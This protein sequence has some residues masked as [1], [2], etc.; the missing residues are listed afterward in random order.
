MGGYMIA[1]AASAFG[2][3]PAAPGIPTNGTTTPFVAQAE[4]QAG[5]S[6]TSVFQSISAMPAYRNM[7]H[8]ELRVMDYLQ[9]RKTPT[10]GA[11]GFGTSTTVS[12][13]GAPASNSAFGSTNTT[14]FGGGGT[15]SAFGSTPSAFGTGGTNSFGSTSTPNAFGSTSQPSAFG[16]GTGFGSSSTGSAFGAPASTSAFGAAAPATSTAFSGTGTSTFGS[17]TPATSGF[18]AFGG[19]TS[20]TKPFGASTFGGGAFGSSTSNATNSAF[21]STAPASNAFGATAQPQTSA[22]GSTTQPSTSGFGTFGLTAAK[23]ATTFGSFGTAASTAPKPFGGFGTTTSSNPANPFATST[24]PSTNTFGLGASSQPAAP[25]AS[26]TASTNPFGASTFGVTNTTSP[27]GASTLNTTSLG[28]STNTPLGNSIF[29]QTQQLP[30]LHASVDQD[31]YGNSSLFANFKSSTAS[32][33]SLVSNTKKQPPLMSMLRTSSPSRSSVKKIRG[34]SSPSFGNALDVSGS[35]ASSP[36]SPGSGTNSPLKFG[37]GLGEDVTVSPLAFQPRSSVKK[38]VIDRTVTKEELIARALPS[39]DLASSPATNQLDFLISAKQKPIQLDSNLEKSAYL[40][41]FQHKGIP[42]GSLSN[43]PQESSLNT[44]QSLDSLTSSIPPSAATRLPATTSQPL[45]SEE[46]EDNA[47]LVQSEWDVDIASLKDG[48]YY[49]KPSLKYIATLRDVK[50]FPDLE[51][52]RKGHGSV[53]FM[54]PVDLSQLHQFKDLLGK[55]VQ[56]SDRSINVYPTGYVAK[57]PSVGEGINVPAVVRL[58]QC[59]PHDKATRDPVKDPDDTRVIKHIKRLKKM[60][61]TKFV[62]YAAETGTWTFQVQHFSRYG[63]YDSDDE[64]S[65]SDSELGKPNIDVDVRVSPSDGMEDDLPP[66]KSLAEGTDEEEEEDD[67]ESETE[68]SDPPSPQVGVAKFAPSRY[69]KLIS[70]DEDS[71]LETESD[72]DEKLPQSSM[73]RYRVTTS[74]S[75]CEPWPKKLGLEPKRVA[76]MQASLFAAESSPVSINVPAPPSSRSAVAHLSLLKPT[77]PPNI[78]VRSHPVKRYDM[79]N[80][81][82]HFAP[83]SSVD[84]GLMLGR[85]F[86][87]SWGSKGQLVYLGKLSGAT[88]NP[89]KG[90]VVIRKVKEESDLHLDTSLSVHLQHTIIE[91]VEGIPQAIPRSSL[92]FADLASQFPRDDRSHKAI[93][94]RLCEVLFDEVDLG[95][96][97]KDRDV[98]SHI[99]AHKRRD[100]FS[101]WLEHTVAKDVED[102]LPSSSARDS[103]YA[104]IFALLTGFQVDRACQSSLDAKNLRLATLL[105]QIGGDETFRNDIALQLSTWKQDQVDPHIPTDLRKIYELLDGNTHIIPNIRGEEVSM[106]NGLDWKRVFGLHFWY[107]VHCAD[108]GSALSSYTQS[109]KRVGGATKPLPWYIDSASKTHS[110][111]DS[112]YELLQLFCS[113]DYP[114]EAALSPR[115]YGPDALDYSIPWHLYVVFSRALHIRDLDDRE[116]TI[117]IEY[118]NGDAVEG[119]SHRADRIT[120]SYASQL[121]LHGAWKWAIFVLLHL[122][123]PECREIAIRDI[124]TRNIE[125]VK[126][127]DQ[128]YL[129]E[130][131]R[132]PVAWIYDSKA[133]FSSY[134]G[135]R[136]GT[137]E[138]LLQAGS[139]I[140]AHDVVVAN[141]A[142]EAVLS[143]DVRLVRSLFDSIRATVVP[144]FAQGGDLY[145]KYADLIQDREVSRVDPTVVSSLGQ[146]TRRYDSTNMK[147]N[148]SAAEMAS[149]V[150]QTVSVCATSSE[151]LRHI[152]QSCLHVAEKQDLVKSLSQ[153]AFAESLRD[154]MV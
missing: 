144:H 8:E 92:R 89:P 67:R 97:P 105:S 122:E 13:F 116:E 101:H 45:A 48:Q 4:K 110:V 88:S 141:L 75:I 54:K 53:K 66:R 47:R 134:K 113:V 14:S 27:F 65:A 70:R 90:T 49:T 68:D 98:L 73:A 31:P 104:R 80:T 82:S 108:I 64:D 136:V 81:A 43:N 9:G 2:S 35:P 154:S 41:P 6:T 71:G 152:P 23:P 38:L 129:I 106:T 5:D 42:N 149:R 37:V 60:P 7:S 26:T 20:A 19:G 86:R 46:E 123:L 95:C 143:N 51:V 18:G 96:T 112:I 87:A 39:R 127:N 150:A 131:L 32:Q 25:F 115:S 121:E 34:F 118:Q 72:D 153:L 140:R 69:I 145:L 128:N 91:D 1:L 99:L 11:G 151:Q 124:L 125:S 30:A 107:G 52:G 130:T 56:F 148:I 84:A 21:G 44:S 74:A 58:E 100:G 77:T 16:G 3:S 50:A 29:P 79:R 83:S 94:Y 117:P 40:S 109:T 135:D 33:T 139:Q 28:S 142:P 146:L 61:D 133:T 93:V 76:V 111:H 22:F 102:S 126:I 85:S 103:H 119:H 78:P 120:L 36:G 10:A 59:W 57:K 132:I 147:L 62:D 137:R 24:A 17:T 15:T 138:N 55:A 63:L 114:L 12:A